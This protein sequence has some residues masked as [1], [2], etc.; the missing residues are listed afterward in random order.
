MLY[1]E[2]SEIK[3]AHRRISEHINATPVLR[4]DFI[5]DFFSAKVFFKFEGFQKT[6]AFKLRGALNAMLSHKE[7]G[8]LS[9]NVTAFSSGNHAQAVA[10]AAKLIGIK[11]KIFI[12]DFNSKFKI[13][14]TRKLGAEVILTKTRQEAEEEF[15]Q[16]VSKGSIPIP[17]YDDDMIIAGQGTSCYEALKAGYKPDAIFATIGGGGWISGT[18]LATQLLHPAC[19]V[20][21][22]EPANANDASISFR[23]GSI[24]KLKDTPS[25][26][27]DGAK[28]LCLSER[29]FQYIKKLNDIIEVSEK[30]IIEFTQLLTAHLKITPEPTSCV[31]AAACFK[32]AVDSKNKGKTA[33][34]MLSGGNLDPELMREIWQ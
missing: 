23:T 21:G 3:K 14:A 30:E 11:A 1:I 12:P 4:S 7:A 34:V 26:I 17:P 27:A 16:E 29:T 33:L 6:G 2:P 20:I 8:K 10:Y 22:A 15:R 25:T 5:D 13:D 19:A 32:W 31:A 24:H 9:G 18:Y 28:T